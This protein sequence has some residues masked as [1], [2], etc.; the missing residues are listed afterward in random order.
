MKPVEVSFTPVDNQRLANLCGVLDENL[1][2]IESAFEVVIARR[3]ERFAL[4][5]SPHQ[6]RLATQALENFYAQAKR[7]LSVEDV[8]LGLIEVTRAK[9]LAAAH[10]GPQLKTRRP[11]L[12]GRTPRQVQY[13]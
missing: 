4:S 7:N 9:D 5:G 3:G 2:Q 10:E 6:T 12:H 13:L 8:Q 11:D 1:R